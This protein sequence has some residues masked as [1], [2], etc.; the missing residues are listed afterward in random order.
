V[1]ATVILRNKLVSMVSRIREALQFLNANRVRGFLDCIGLY[2]NLG[3][4]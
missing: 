2:T 3:R 4:V 1:R